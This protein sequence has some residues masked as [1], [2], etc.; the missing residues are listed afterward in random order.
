MKLQTYRIQLGE[1]QEYLDKYQERI[2]FIIPV[3]HNGTTGM[4][5]V[6]IEEK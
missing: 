3:T 2:K 4:Y 1:L 5:I 6:V